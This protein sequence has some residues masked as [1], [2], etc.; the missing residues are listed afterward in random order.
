M[1]YG[2]SENQLGGIL[3]QPPKGEGMMEGDLFIFPSW[4]TGGFHYFG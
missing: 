2:K 1:L 4:D 3:H